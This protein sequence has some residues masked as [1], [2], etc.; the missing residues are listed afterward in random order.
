M[1]TEFIP[2]P[3]VAPASTTTTS[4]TTTTTVCVSTIVSNAMSLSAFK[5]IATGI[6]AFS[7]YSPSTN[8][9]K[10]KVTGFRIKD[11]PAAG[12]GIL[13][14]NDIAVTDEQLISVQ[15][16]GKLVYAPKADADGSATIN[17]ITETSCGNSAQVA[18]TFTVTQKP[19][20]DGCNCYTSTTSSTSTTTT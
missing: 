8:R 12:D 14:L 15:D 1:A 5:G 6:P 20:D 13:Y 3:C 2:Y 11:L 16:N 9:N 4:S 18:V 19:D 17:F 7:W 10:I